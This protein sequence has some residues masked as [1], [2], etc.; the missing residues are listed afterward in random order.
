VLSPSDGNAMGTY[1]ETYGYDA[2]GNLLTMLHQVST[3]SWLRRYAYAEPSQIDEAATGNRLSATSLPGDPDGGPFSAKNE[4]DAH[5]NT[6]RMA[7]L[8]QLVWDERDR[9][10]STTRQVVNTGTPETTYYAYDGG[11]QRVRKVTDAA[12]QQN[13]EPRRR[14]ERLYLGGVEIYR[15]FG[16]DRSTVT[17]ARETLHVPV[18]AERIAV[19]ETRTVGNDPALAQAIRFQ[20][21]NHLGSAV[22]ELDEAAAV[23]SYEEYFPYGSS[24]YQAVRS[25]L[26]TP[27]RYRYTGKERDEESGL[28]YHGARYY[29]PWL[30]RWTSCD[31]KHTLPRPIRREP[32]REPKEGEPLPKTEETEPQATCDSEIVDLYRY[33]QDNPVVNFDPDGK[34][35]VSKV[36]LT[37]AKALARRLFKELGQDLAKAVTKRI[38]REAVKRLAED[39]SQKALKHALE[40]T[41]EV[42]EKVVHTLFK[43]GLGKAEI[44]ELIKTTLKKGN[45]AVLSEISENGKLAFVIEKEFSEQIGSKVEQKILRV[46]VDKEGNLV[47]A[48]PV[49]KLLQRVSIKGIQVSA[50]LAAV[51]AVIAF[52]ESEANAAQKDAEARRKKAEERNALET[53]L[54]WVV[55]FG[56]AESSNI[57]IEPNFSA[58]RAHTDTAIKEVEAELGRELSAEEKQQIGSDIYQ[59][60]VDETY[61]RKE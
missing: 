47:T 59:I 7:H 37:A 51:A 20:Y 34:D 44:V 45:A 5:G 61:K 19:V 53:V 13:Q 6:T 36:A 14:A 8:P 29:A 21:S 18:G 54:E 48:F 38:G 57:A 27:K 39:V 24:S 32:R 16:P 25:T 33:A 60:W 9:L 4:Y 15:E 1:T 35:P 2:V 55:P 40:H 31:P 3:G 49:S 56:L 46:V 50:Q 42:S 28:Y 52:Y 43:K 22:L 26:E 30:G 23:V 10:R 11:G 58:I 17:L 41:G 12:A